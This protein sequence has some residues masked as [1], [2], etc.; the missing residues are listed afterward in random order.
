MGAE[1]EALTR[2]TAWS[3]KPKRADIGARLQSVRST[4]RS[5]DA[6]KTSTALFTSWSNW[7]PLPSNLQEVS[8][9]F[10]G[11]LE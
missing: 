9:G 3:L 1:A 4:V 7:R 2:H 10:L 11:A 8:T 6:W 5:V